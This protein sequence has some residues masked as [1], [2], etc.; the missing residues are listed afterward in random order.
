MMTFEEILY[1]C[2]LVWLFSLIAYGVK[3]G[4]DYLFGNEKK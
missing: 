2:G 1:I 4:F 3:K